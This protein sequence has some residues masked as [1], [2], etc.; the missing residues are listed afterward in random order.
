MYYSNEAALFQE[1]KKKQVIVLPFDDNSPMIRIALPPMACGRLDSI[2]W[3][4]IRLE[5]TATSICAK[6]SERILQFHTLIGHLGYSQRLAN[7]RSLRL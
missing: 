2:Q 3:V 7:T 4:P 6:R 5:K 1:Q